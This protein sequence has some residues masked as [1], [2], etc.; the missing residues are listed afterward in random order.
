[1]N[2]IALDFETA[3]YEPTS[4]CQVGLAV[5]EDNVLTKTY[6][7]LI[8]PTPYYFAPSHTAVHGLSY[9][10]V[11]DKKYFPDYWDNLYEILNNNYIVAHN[12]HFD[13]RILYKTLTYFKLPMPNIKFACTYILSTQLIKIQ[14]YN[15]KSVAQH[16]GIE[17]FNH[18]NAL[19]DA[20]TAGYILL[21]LMQQS[22][23]FSLEE[24]TQKINYTLGSIQ[25]NSFTPFHK[26]KK[27]K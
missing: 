2:F 11:I 25:N 27:T 20:I 16:F 1:M 5:F 9:A 22:Q 23:I 6:S 8:K 13:L 7:Q 17:E 3:N 24:L 26:I 15:L 19:D 4:I 21:N 10:D 14:R 12:A 18:H